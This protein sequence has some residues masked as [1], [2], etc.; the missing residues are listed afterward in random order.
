MSPLLYGVCKKKE[1]KK[2]VLAGESRAWGW[3]RAL[4]IM[5]VTCAC[6]TAKGSRENEHISNR[7]ETSKPEHRDIPFHS[8]RREKEMLEICE[9]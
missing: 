9:Y 6:L 7:I 2:R 5:G 4:A 8:K 1:E 3:R